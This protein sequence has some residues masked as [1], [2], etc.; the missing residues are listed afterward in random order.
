MHRVL[1]ILFAGVL[2]CSA[3]VVRAQDIIEAEI[4]A[5]TGTSIYL[6]VGESSGVVRDSVV[7]LTTGEIS[8]QYAVVVDLAPNSC[9]AELQLE[10]PIPEV[11]DPVTV[12]VLVKIVE[13]LEE[14]TKPKQPAVPDHPPWQR[15]VDTTDADAPLLAP[16]VR[17]RPEERPT[18]FHGRIFNQIRY[19]RDSGGNRD[20]DYTFFRLGARF[21]VSNPFQNGG[22]LLFRGN[23]DHRGSDISSASESDTE[24]RIERLSYAV[25]GLAHSPYRAEFGRFY[26]VFVPE[27]G[28][29]DGAEAALLTRGNWRIGAGAGLYPAPFVDRDLGDDYGVHFFADYRPDR[30]GAMSG[31]LAYQQTWHKGAPDQ[32]LLIGRFNAKP[33][34][35]LSVYGLALVNL[36]TD[37]DTV[38]GSGVELTQGNINV[39]YRPDRSKGGSI[40]Y[41]RTRY[42]ELKRRDLDLLPDTILRDGQVDRITVSAW[43]RATDDI[44]LTARANRWSDQSDDGYGGQLGVEWYEIWRDTAS[45]RASVFFTNGTFSD[46]VGARFRVG[47]RF[48]GVD[49]D[50]RY[51]IFSYTSQG[52]IANNETRTR[53]TVQ[54]DVSWDA[55]PWNYSIDVS[56]TFGDSESTYGIRSL[57]EYRF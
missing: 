23:L 27:I 26:S 3:A 13:P 41:S 21:E 1:S 11:G 25:G 15:A 30:G 16:A 19:T 18:K 31:T 33:T 12:E 28:L 20:N 49:V 54:S 32:N 53:H 6:D 4:T 5:V 45:A 57:I 34:K 38:K 7:R 56:Y 40:G 2:I 39:R 17:R 50:L 52:Q 8:G 44:R 10:S 42:A 9:R 51:D 47:D 35:E 48:R 29:I 14:D 24:G 22:R 36:Y 43:V 37:S 46:G 55:G